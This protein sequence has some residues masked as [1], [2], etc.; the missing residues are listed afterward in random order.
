MAGKGLATEKF[1]A[2]LR[3]RSKGKTEVRL[4]LLIGE[5]VQ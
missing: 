3:K 4:G 1:G 2:L 5:R